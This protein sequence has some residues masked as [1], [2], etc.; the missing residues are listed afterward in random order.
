MSNS[1][2]RGGRFTRWNAPVLLRSSTGGG[3]VMSVAC[4]VAVVTLIVLGVQFITYAGIAAYYR[5][6]LSFVARQGAEFMAG[7]IFWCNNPK[8][9]ANQAQASERTKTVVN[10]LLEQMGLP[11]ASKIEVGADNDEAT[12]TLTVTGLA[13][14]NQ[15]SILPAFINLT[16]TENKLFREDQPAGL[17]VLYRSNL[18]DSAVIIPCYGRTRNG[19]GD[20]VNH[21]SYKNK[22]APRLRTDLTITTSGVSE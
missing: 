12:V 10:D 7:E 21:L 22:L 4:T 8:P 14:P 9:G 18:A 13:M 20:L 17:M 5:D 15:N 6:K 19:G 2:C 11:A 3:L 16:I 1:S